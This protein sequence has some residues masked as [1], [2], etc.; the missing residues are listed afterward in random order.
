MKNSYIYIVLVS[1]LIIIYFKDIWS[2]LFNY[3]FKEGIGGQVGGS[4]STGYNNLFSTNPNIQGDWNLISVDGATTNRSTSKFRVGWYDNSSRP[5]WQIT[6]IDSGSPV[7]IGTYSAKGLYMQNANTMIVGTHGNDSEKYIGVLSKKYTFRVSKIDATPPPT[8]PPPTIPPPSLPKCTYGGEWKNSSPECPSCYNIDNPETKTQIQG[9]NNSSCDGP[10]T[11][12]RT[13]NCSDSVPACEYCKYSDWSAWSECSKPCNGGT[14]SRT[15]TLKSGKGPCNELSQTENCNVQA[16]SPCEYGEVESTS[17]CTVDCGGG[18][19]SVTYKLVNKHGNDSCPVKIESKPC[20]IDPCPDIMNM[21]TPT[22]DE[23]WSLYLDN[24]Y[25][26]ASFFTT[27][28]ENAGLKSYT[29]IKSL[30]QE[31]CRAKYKEENAAILATPEGKNIGK[32]FWTDD[33]CP[34]GL[35]KIECND[36]YST[37]THDWRGKYR[38]YGTVQHGAQWDGLRTWATDDERKEQADKDCKYRATLN[39]DTPKNSYNLDATNAEKYRDKLIVSKFQLS[40][41][42]Q[43][44]QFPYTVY[45]YYVSAN[46]GVCS[47][48]NNGAAVTKL[49]LNN[50]PNDFGT[51]LNAIFINSNGVPNIFYSQIYFLDGTFDLNKYDI[52]MIVGKNPLKIIP[53]NLLSCT[54][55]SATNCMNNN[56]GKNLAISFT[57]NVK[58]TNSTSNRLQI[59]GLTTESTGSEKCVFGAWICPNSNNLILRRA[60]TAGTD[61]VI[62]NCKIPIEVGV[63][64]KFHILC[65]GSTSSYDI[66]KNDSLIDTFMVTSPPLYVTGKCYIYTSFNNYKTFDGTLSNVVFLSSDH[67]TFKTGDI[68]S[69]INYMNKDIDLAK[70]EKKQ[71]EGF[72]NEYSPLADGSY[73]SQDLRNMESELLKELNDFNREYSNYKKY[74]YNNRHNVTGDTSVKFSQTGPT[75]FPNLQIGGSLNEN[76]IYK[77]ILKDLQIFN[78]ALDVTVNLSTIDGQPENNMNNVE[79]TQNTVVNMRQ[80]LDYKLLELNELENSLAVENKQKVLSSMY[81]NILW[82]GL[83]TSIVYYLFVHQRNK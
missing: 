72:T 58:N 16:C 2:P 7:Y 79:K 45:Y 34:A 66:Y 14:R 46:K 23:Y 6:S 19:Q 15:R 21:I 61:S 80:S 69:A 51:M 9:A 65:N 30:T 40:I 68:D 26:S 17:T 50:N 57:I 48:T 70:L 31:E 1:I 52:Y 37:T 38:W 56:L 47:I 4:A 12:S 36:G 22:Y 3:H 78:H 67:R 60:D 27:N 11:T 10:T 62:S 54:T 73:S 24:K 76:P 83:A 41:D 77:N 64:C 18:T 75:D 25:N 82:T 39:K 20:N 13:I 74:I 35:Y 55:L 53:N 59:I 63:D 28:I 5:S 29:K 49:Q 71:L 33:I 81:A 44:I 43:G 42:L 8:I 32:D